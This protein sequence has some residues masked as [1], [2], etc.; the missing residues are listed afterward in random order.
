M[1]R[2][3]WEEHLKNNQILHKIDFLPLHFSSHIYGGSVYQQLN[4]KPYMPSALS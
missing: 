4:S 3:Q 2:V 1:G